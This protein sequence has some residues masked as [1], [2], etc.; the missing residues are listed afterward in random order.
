MN[1]IYTRLAAHLGD[2]LEVRTVHSHAEFM[3]T[4]RQDAWLARVLDGKPTK[5]KRGKR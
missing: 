3:A 1:P 2:P 4:H 5:R